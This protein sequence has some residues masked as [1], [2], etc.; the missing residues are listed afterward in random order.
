MAK[1]LGWHV[2]V[3]DPRPAWA[4][5][6]RFPLADDTIVVR[7]DAMPAGLTV[8]ADTV[9]VIMTHHYRHDV[10]LLRALWPLP[11]AYLGLLGPRKRAEKI[12]ADLEADG[13]TA[14]PEMRARLHAPVGLDLGAEAPEEVAL[15]I[16]AEMTAVRS[17]R[18]ARPL[19]DR[20]KP[21]HG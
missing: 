9:V 2:T 10:P 5:T 19:R 6:E 8:D 12:V 7:P 15:A 18:D 11:L 20:A 3:A 16:L 13:F 4:T 21:I 1:E 17:D 14:T